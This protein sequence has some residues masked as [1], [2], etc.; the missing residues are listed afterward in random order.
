MINPY[1]S[2]PDVVSSKRDRRRL[3]ELGT[4]A[5][6]NDTSNRSYGVLCALI[7][8]TVTVILGIAYIA[9]FRSTLPPHTPGH[10]QDG[11]GGL[12]G[13]V[14]IFAS[15]FVAVA[16]WLVGSNLEGK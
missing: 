4:K 8:F 15:P 7:G 14:I 3:Y 5:D 11:T 16:A 12:L 2:L 9:W 10:G 1:K 13:I 6:V